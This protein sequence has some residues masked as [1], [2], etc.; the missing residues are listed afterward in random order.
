MYFSA[1][2]IQ[3][4]PYVY[5]IN[6]HKFC[7]WVWLSTSGWA[8][9]ADEQ[10]MWHN[11][12]LHTCLGKCVQTCY[13]FNKLHTG[14]KTH[15]YFFWPQLDLSSALVPAT[16]AK[17]ITSTHAHFEY[18]ENTWS[19]SPGKVMQRSNCAPLLV[20]TPVSPQPKKV[21]P[22]HWDPLTKG[23]ILGTLAEFTIL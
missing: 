18:P 2:I 7:P 17:G 13:T 8:A 3:Y 10:V 19:Y 23:W 6:N 22:G 1:E 16:P 11:V 20:T 12:D 4:C 14:T 5:G 15:L 9:S 21:M